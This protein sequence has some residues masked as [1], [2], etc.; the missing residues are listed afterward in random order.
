M[1]NILEIKEVSKVYSN[2]VYAN[3]KVNFSVREGEIHA[4]VGENG[5]GKTTLMKVIFGIEKPDGGEIL[6]NGKPVEF[7]SPNDAIK[8]GICMVHQ[9]FMLV[10]SLT[11]AENCALGAETKKGLFIDKDLVKKRVKSICEQYN[12]NL[13]PDALVEDISVGLKQRVEILKTLYRDAQIIILDEPTAVLTPQET[14]EL[15]NQLISL[16]EK[17]HTIIFISHK[18][19]EVKRITDRVSV[20]RKGEMV[21]TVDTKDVNEQEISNLMIGESVNLEINKQPARVGD[22]VLTIDRLCAK[23]DVG[24]P[25]FENLCLKVRAGEILGLASIEGN[26]QQQLIEIITSQRKYESGSVDF[27]GRQVKFGKIIE[28]R[29]HG[30]G[31][32]PGDRMTMGVARDMTIEENIISNKLWDKALYSGMLLS[33]GKI[34]QLGERLIEE[35]KVKAESPKMPVGTLSGG[36]IQKVVAAREFSI[37]ARLIVAD[38][39]TRGIDVLAADFIHKT[40]VGL[41][42]KGAGILLASAD[43]DELLKVSDS[44]IVMFEGKIT[45]YFEDAASLQQ[46]ELGNYM[47]GVKKMESSYIMEAYYEK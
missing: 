36:N 47:L 2:G 6:V 33:P 39:P 41:R 22:A 27:L 42:D 14:D 1:K 23:D 28:S 4:L 34:E 37:D 17:G 11:V 9:H 21:A 20:L 43:L 10:P 8:N 35:Y 40:I 44:I 5:A 12:L 32:I 16:K 45:A 25:L 7:N 3:K 15:F 38:Q 30:M 29:K 46:M 26:G 24:K 13:E 31:Y 19:H 18:L